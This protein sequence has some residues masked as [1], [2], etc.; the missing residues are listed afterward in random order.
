[1]TSRPWGKAKGR[2]AYRGAQSEPPHHPLHKHKH[3]ARSISKH[4]YIWNTMTQL[5]SRL[6][7]KPMH[8]L[9][10]LLNTCKPQGYR[11]PHL[12]NCMK[13]LQHQGASSWQCLSRTPLKKI[14]CI[15][16]PFPTYQ[17]GKKSRCLWHRSLPRPLCLPADHH[18]QLWKAVVSCRAW[19]SNMTG[20]LAMH[21]QA[22]KSQI[23]S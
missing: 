4:H 18:P 20:C 19:C 5:R 6:G 13:L 16:T 7:T 1:M 23:K 3:K 10:C 17:R 21:T 11:N 12:W 8:S 2:T 9:L 15:F 22:Q 14:S